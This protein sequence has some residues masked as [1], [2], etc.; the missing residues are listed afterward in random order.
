MKKRGDQYYAVFLGVFALVF[1][2][3]IIRGIADIIYNGFSF[4][5]IVSIMLM[6]LLVVNIIRAAIFFYEKGQK[7]N[8]K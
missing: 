7:L 1:I 5:V 2:F 6:I 4:G 8:L 3:L